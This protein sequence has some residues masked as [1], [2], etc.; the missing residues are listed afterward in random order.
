MVVCPNH[1]LTSERVSCSVCCAQSV[2]ERD[3]YWLR[4][5][6]EEDKEGF[7]ERLVAYAAAHEGEDMQVVH[8]VS[9]VAAVKHTGDSVIW[10]DDRRHTQMMR[11][12]SKF[13]STATGNQRSIEER[14]DEQ[15]QKMDEQAK[16]TDE[17]LNLIQNLQPAPASTASIFKK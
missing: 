2:Q 15:A 3:P 17:L 8:P 7:I 14:M 16:K 10:Q 5:V 13:R 1:V 4:K 6:I 11:M 9:R 12:L